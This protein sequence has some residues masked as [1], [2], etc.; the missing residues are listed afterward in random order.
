MRVIER[1]TG[2]ISVS[3]DPAVGSIDL[4]IEV[5]GME[6]VRVI[7]LGRDEARRLAALLLFQAERLDRP[8]PGWGVPSL[9]IE[10]ESA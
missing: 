9:G 1:Q 7:H 6:G 5:A 2:Q 3:H 8:R 4:Q 10:Q